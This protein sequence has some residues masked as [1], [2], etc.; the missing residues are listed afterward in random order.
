MGVFRAKDKK[1]NAF[2]HPDYKMVYIKVYIRKVS[3]NFCSQAEIV[4]LHRKA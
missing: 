2:A 3:N 4:Q 1:Q